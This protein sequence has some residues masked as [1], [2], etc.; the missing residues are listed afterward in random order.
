MIYSGSDFDWRKYNWSNAYDQCHYKV[1]TTYDRTT[2]DYATYFFLYDINWFS[3]KSV[4]WKREVIRIN[5]LSI[6]CMV[7]VNRTR[8]GPSGF[9]INCQRCILLM[10]TDVC[11]TACYTTYD[12]LRIIIKNMNIL[13]L[14]GHVFRSMYY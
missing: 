6:P 3:F 8:L 13:K 7:V 4:S 12:L 2:W 11:A 14:M 5:S 1:Y 10:M 9:M